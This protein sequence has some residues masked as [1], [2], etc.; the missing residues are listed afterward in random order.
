MK[1]L[2]VT[3][4]LIL[5]LASIGLA[6]DEDTTL[7]PPPVDT[8]IVPAPVEDT[9]TDAQKA[10][11]SFEERRKLFQKEMEK[12]PRFDLWS[13]YDSIM[14][15][16]TSERFN[17]RA[18]LER[19][20]FHDAGDYFR[21]DPSYFIIDRQSTPLRKTVQPFGLTGDRLSFVINGMPIDPF[22]HVIEPDGMVDLNDIPTAPN[23]D[24]YL[25]PGPIGQLFG[26]EQAVA[27]LV[28]RGQELAT[29]TAESAFL[30]DK[31]SFAYNHVRGQYAKN[32]TSGRE[33]DLSIGYRNAEGD[34]FAH[35]ED[36]YHY[37]GRVYVPVGDNRGVRA[38]GW[39]YDREG[40]FPVRPATG[41]ATPQRSRVDR[42]A[43]VS[44]EFFN[45]NNSVRNEVGYE[46]LRQASDMDHL[47]MARF[48][49]TGK[50]LFAV[51]E[52]LAGS[53][54][55]KAR[56]DGDYLEY[57]TGP[58]SFDRYSGGVNLSLA[59]NGPGW[60][61]A[62]TGGAKYDEDFKWLPNGTAALFR[63]SDRGLAMLSVGYT[64][65]APTM[66]ELN[67]PYQQTT[68][69]AEGTDNYADQGN[70]NL[71]SEKQLTGNL[72]L[73]Y[74]SLDN[75]T[76]LSITG[77]H[78]TDGID[79]QVR[80]LGNALGEWKLFMPIN[81]DIDFADFRL[82]N[83][84]RLKDFLRLNAGGA[85]HYLDYENYEDKPYQ[86]E[87]QL[88]SGLELHLYWPQKLMDLFAYG[89]VVYAGAYDG[90][91]TTG[92]GEQVIANVKFSF[93]LKD[94]RFHFVIQNVL[95]TT[96]EPYE[97]YVIP[98]RYNYYGFTWDFLD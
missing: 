77:G 74:G 53:T 49:Y 51:R 89:E 1:I 46:L 47:F 64:E 72:M 71:G 6:E 37:T 19:S 2:G 84:L 96:Y 33:I 88:F 38:W 66:H 18:Q 3:A 39:L 23:H 57:E 13:F 14:N 73:E 20:W 90:Y 31:G 32:F 68:I 45:D 7:V 58:D 9:L 92:L 93:R 59:R 95:S 48:A 65:R 63:E 91:D 78:I 17:Q 15:W 86:P 41:A 75:S 11:A 4:I 44:Y 67:M 21:F 61:F 36:A 79:W 62:V 26:G 76:N 27:T 34:L 56:L 52:W 97:D 82:L 85:Y 22:E 24:I 25:M 35:Q 28:T 8:A 69:Y 55:I 40:S 83:K 30:V 87:Y 98:G 54:I 16:F 12:E 5:L 70:P 94:F 80:E 81:G 60:R 42:N 43:S 29:T 50:S 10:M